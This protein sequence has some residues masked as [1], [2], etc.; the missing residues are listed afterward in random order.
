MRKYR[1]I[2]ESDLDR[3]S[4]IIRETEEIDEIF[5]GSKLE[6]FF[7]GVKGLYQ[8]EGFY[9]FKY[10]SKIKNRSTKVKNELVDIKKFVQE[11]LK[12]KENIDKIKNIAPEKK[13]RLLNLIDLVSQLWKPFEIPFSKAV[14]EINALSS[15]KLKGE[16]LDV[17]PGS[18]KSAL[19][20]DYM[21]DKD[22]TSSSDD[23]SKPE[24]INPTQTTTGPTTNVLATQTITEEIKRF[25]QL[26]R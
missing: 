18:K 13:L 24:L 2:N 10:L 16:R 9:F 25:K 26:M 5:T 1:K 17:I 4:K 8:G 11:L 21:D 6:D 19:G 20:K 3:L 14:D 23:L 15:Q 12:L 22:E 7:Q